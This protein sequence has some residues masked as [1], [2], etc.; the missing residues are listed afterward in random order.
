MTRTCTEGLRSCQHHRVINSNRVS[1]SRSHSYVIKHT[2]FT[3]SR[4]TRTMFCQSYHPSLSLPHPVLK[5][6]DRCSLGPAVDI[7]SYSER[8]WKGNTAKSALIRKVGACCS[9]EGT[10]H[11]LFLYYFTLRAKRR[12]VVSLCVLLQGYK[13]M[14]QRF[15]SLR[16]V[17]GDNYCAL[18][19]TLFQVLSHS[20]QLPAWLQEDD[21]TLVNAVFLDST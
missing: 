13:E 1:T 15:S 17:R 6:E 7:L 11:T 8:E 20:T 14:S 12:P 9:S 10:F 18:R 21:I 2:S 5:G 3:L 19:A 4:T 16:R